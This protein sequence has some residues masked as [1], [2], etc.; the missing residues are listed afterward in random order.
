MHGEVADKPRYS[1]NFRVGVGK[2]EKGKKRREG[3]NGKGGL[4]KRANVAARKEIEVGG[5]SYL[6][7]V[8]MSA[9]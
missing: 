1:F 2:K 5:G 7:S 6:D 8:L 3:K 9:Q 4:I